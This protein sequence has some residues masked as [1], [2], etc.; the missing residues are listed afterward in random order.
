MKKKMLLTSISASFLAL[1]PILTSC[2]NDDA[3][4]QKNDDAFKNESARTEDFLNSMNNSEISPEFFVD[5]NSKYAELKIKYQNAKNSNEKNEVLSSLKKFNDSKMKEWADNLLAVIDKSQ[6]EL[7]KKDTNSTSLENSLKVIDESLNSQKLANQKLKDQI[8]RLQHELEIATQN[9]SS[10]AATENEE[11]TKNFLPRQLSGKL[12]LIEAQKYLITWYGELIEFLGKFPTANEETQKAI[13]SLK[14]TLEGLKTSTELA[15]EETKKS[16]ERFATRK[17]FRVDLAITMD[18]IKK[19]A[20]Q[21]KSIF[22]Y[23]VPFPKSKFLEA[24]YDWRIYNLQALHDAVVANNSDVYSEIATQNEKTAEEFQNGIALTILEV[25]KL[26]EDSK[27]KAKN[28]ADQLFSYISIEEKYT[29]PNLLNKFVNDEFAPF[30][31]VSLKMTEYPLYSRLLENEKTAK[32]DVYY[33]NVLAQLGAFKRN[34]GHKYLNSIGFRKVY[35]QW[36]KFVENSLNYKYNAD[37]RTYYEVLGTFT[38]ATEGVKTLA[39]NSSE[40]ESKTTEIKNKNAELLTKINELMKPI[41]QKANK[42]FADD[43]SYTPFVDLRDNINQYFNSAKRMTEN[44]YVEAFDKFIAL[45]LVFSYV[46]H[47]SQL[48]N[49][50]EFVGIDPKSDEM[51]ALFNLKSKP[52]KLLKRLNQAKSDLNDKKLAKEFFE[53]KIYPIT[54]AIVLPDL[55]SSST[56]DEEKLAA[57]KKFITDL[58]EAFDKIQDIQNNMD[59]KYESWT[60]YE[61]FFEDYYETKYSEIK[62]RYEELNSK[63]ELSYSDKSFAADL[64]DDISVQR[65]NTV[66]ADLKAAEEELKQKQAAYDSAST[67][68]NPKYYTV[69]NQE[70]YAFIRQWNIKYRPNLAAIDL[71]SEKDPDREA[72]ELFKKYSKEWK[73]GHED[74]S[75]KPYI[76]ITNLDIDDINPTDAAYNGD[77]I[78]S[79]YTSDKI[80]VLVLEKEKEYFEAYEAYYQ[81]KV[82]NENTDALKTALDNARKAYY[83]VLNDKHYTFSRSAYAK[84]NTSHYE[85]GKLVSLSPL[86]LA[87]LYATE[88]A[89]YDVLDFLQN[90][91]IK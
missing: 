47:M 62:N 23:D 48:Y 87:S 81:A 34:E 31:K 64:K 20:S 65:K 10:G 90:E 45:N 14:E 41:N 35:N 18:R 49:Y 39:V 40:V 66:I 44:N 22:P 42:E 75:T 13:D 26:Y 17:H 61:Y 72:V 91:Y 59:S 19:L 53:E 5:A 78:D 46:T 89:S 36:D 88:L 58:K 38:E 68:A 67:D 51:E 73:F 21:Y 70:L 2:I 9:T 24:L 16:Q 69:P 71:D 80:K 29:L 55:N 25:K 83:D 43:A 27:A 85:S 37:A 11:I 79:A 54:D 15:L 12:A 82:Q 76:H 63:T 4:S 3:Q 33:N 8:E 60:E 57:Y 28:Y 84:F 77:E 6:K 74:T 32:L 30:L 86:K 52:E 56:S 50:W 7:S 1:S